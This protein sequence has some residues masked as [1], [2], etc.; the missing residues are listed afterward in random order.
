M[1]KM[2]FDLLYALTT[3]DHNRA[4]AKNQTN[5]SRTDVEIMKSSEEAE[6]Q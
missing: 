5:E 3:N 1:V 4:L 2:I 6:G